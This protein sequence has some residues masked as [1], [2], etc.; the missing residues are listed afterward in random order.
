MS[1][2]LDP[3]YRRPVMII[4]TG[5]RYSSVISC[6]KSLHGYPSRITDVIEG[7]INT[8]MNLTFRYLD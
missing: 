8:Y 1:F 4:E 7:K 6:A 3:K 2:Y 5:K